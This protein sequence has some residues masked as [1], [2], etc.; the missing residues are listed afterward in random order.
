MRGASSKQKVF[1]SI[2]DRIYRNPSPQELGK[3]PTIS[4]L[5]ATNLLLRIRTVEGRGFRCWWTL[6][7]WQLLQL[8]QNSLMSADSPFQIYH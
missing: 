7:H 2:M 4:R 1:L 5:M 8:L 3:G 6:D